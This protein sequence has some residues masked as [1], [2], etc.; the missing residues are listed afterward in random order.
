MDKNIISYTLNAP[1]DL[2]M[3]IILILLWILLWHLIIKRILRKCNVTS[4]WYNLYELGAFGTMAIVI[5]INIIIILLIASIEALIELGIKM[6]FPLAIFWGGV[7]A[8]AYLLI[9]HCK[10]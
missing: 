7:F 3:A 1:F 2:G 8:F 9:R 6:L 4:F 10:K 5:F